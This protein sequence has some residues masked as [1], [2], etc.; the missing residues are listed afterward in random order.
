MVNCENC[1]KEVQKDKYQLH[2]NFC[3]KNVTKCSFCYEPISINEI[4]EHTVTQ[5][6]SIDTWREAICSLDTEKL[7]KMQ[8]HGNDPFL[9]RDT[10]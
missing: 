9:M 10:D 8:Q 6:G 4:E 1:G 5:K 7:I 3:L 2:Y